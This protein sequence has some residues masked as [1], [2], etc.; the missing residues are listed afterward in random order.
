MARCD[1]ACTSGAMLFWNFMMTGVMRD[2][3]SGTT[4]WNFC[5]T[6]E[7]WKAVSW[8]NSSIVNFSA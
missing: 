1:A 5:P 6:G 2:M 4:L 8:R 3:A 7:R